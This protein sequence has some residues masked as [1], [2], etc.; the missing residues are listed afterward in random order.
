V[1]ISTVARILGLGTKQLN[2]WYKEHL[3]HYNIDTQTGQWNGHKIAIEVDIL[4]G[5]VLKEKIV[6]IVKPENMGA[7]MAIDD[8]QIGKDVFTIL[9]NQETQKIA[10]MVES[11]KADELKASMQLLGNENQKIESISCDMAPSYLKLCRDVWPK[12][13]LVIDKFHVIKHVYDAVQELRMEEKKQILQ[14]MPKGKQRQKSHELFSELELLQRSRNLLNKQ[15]INWGEPQKQIMK[16]VFEKFPKIK[17]GYELAQEFRTWYDKSNCEMSEMAIERGL[18]NWY[19]KVEISK[20]QPFNS[21]VKMIEKHETEI[22][23]YF[24]TKITSAKAERLNGKIERFLSNNYGT[25][26][27]D[28]FLYRVKGYFS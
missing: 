6:T 13:T 26:N 18:F 23:A 14:Q 22:I 19:D 21:V 16:L 1:N 10:L 4:T 12:A 3:S 27:K 28:F 20:I 11:V 25:K 15:K 8:K 2:Y 7:K 24:S 17:Q 9:T 5:E